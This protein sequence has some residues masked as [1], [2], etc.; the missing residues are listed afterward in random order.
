VETFL[1]EVGFVQTQHAIHKKSWP[2]TK[3]SIIHFDRNELKKHLKKC[4]RK[5]RHLFRFERCS[6]NYLEKVVNDKECMVS[7][8]LKILATGDFFL[9]EIKKIEE[10]FLKEAEH[11]YDLSVNPTQNFVGGFGGILLHNTEA[12]AL[13]EAMRIGALANVVAGTVHAESPYGVYDRIV[14]DLGVPPTSFKACDLIAICSMLRSPDGLHRFK[15]VIEL[16]EVRKAWKED[17][18]AE[19]G[20]VPLMQYS[21]K[22]DRL[23]PT[24]VLLDGES[25]VLNEIAK[26]VREWHGAWDLVWE[27]ILLRSRVKE[28]MLD[29]ALKLNRPEILEADWSVG[30]NE[31]FH[32]ISE[33]VRLEVGALDSEMI[34]QRWLE[35]FK[36]RLK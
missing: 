15:R 11:V 28:T 12:L 26:R 33:R 5:Y 8:Q 13:F 34:Y 17:P 19:G 35:W 20:F 22:E 4:P 6:K 32:V 1:R 2:H 25:W 27:N 30:A 3:S 10:V 24:D 21:A 7:Q 9:D 16:T 36:E 18:E 31:M 29:F 14:H 23:K